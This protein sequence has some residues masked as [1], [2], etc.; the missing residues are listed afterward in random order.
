MQSP[1]PEFERDLDA[2]LRQVPLPAHLVAR[3]RRAALVDDAGLDAALCYVA[4]PAGLEERLRRA[5]IV[6]DEGL[7]AVLGEVPVPEGLTDRLRRLVFATDDGLDEAIRDVPFPRA[8]LGRWQRPSKSWTRLA[9]LTKWATAA[10]L[11]IVIGLS[12]FGAMLALLVATYPLSEVSRS[13]L[14][15]SAPIEVRQAH[16]P[17]EPDFDPVTI[18]P[19]GSPADDGY[20]EGEAVPLPE[21]RLVEG[22]SPRPAAIDELNS[23][24]AADVRNNLFLDANAFDPRW[25]VLTAHTLYDDQLRLEKVPGPI[26]R[27]IDLPLVPGA[28]KLFLIRHGVHPF[29]YPAA[30]PQ[31]QVSRVPLAVDAS[32]YELTR[33]HLE[34]DELPPADAVRAEDFLAAVDYDFPPPKRGVLG[35]TTAAGVSPFGAKGVSLLQI[36]VQ[37]RE[38]ADHKHS[39]T[40]L[41]LAIDV[42][43]SMRWGGRLEM[44]RRALGYVV[45]RL[46]PE[47]LISLVAFSEDAQV[48]LEEGGPEE[49]DQLLCAIDLLSV[50]HATNVGAGLRQAYAVARSAESFGKSATRV[51]LVTDGLA[52]LGRETTDPIERCLAEAAGRKKAGEKIG[53]EV[54]NLCQEADPDGQSEQDGQLASFARSGGGK[55]HR[56]ANA[57]QIRLALLEVINGRSELVATDAR[58]TVTFNPK[59][60]VMYRLLGHEAKAMAGLMPPRTEADFHAGQSAAALYEVVLKEGS[61]GDEIAT[62]ELSWQIPGGS[63]VDRRTNRR[64]VRRGQFA[65]S[66]VQ[67]PLSLQ[68]AALVA[69]T[70]EVLRKSPFARVPRGEH[71]LS[72]VLELASVADT[73]LYERPTFVEFISVVEQADAAKPYRSGGRR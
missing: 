73:R 62:A 16:E 24:F 20:W 14:V 46:G 27:G 38:L 10:S 57:D 69:Q 28:D 11:M 64:K 26:R 17:A 22:Q 25:G 43:A 72:G 58:L 9:R 15:S 31:L 67:S 53:L 37:A 18:A 30:H 35:V 4:V 51:V 33:R 56:A 5:V 48:L 68:Q 12:Y 61:S 6:D 50:R 59:V 3:L 19:D 1:E 66:F 60:V 41:V 36:G 7:D 49:A 71:R 55:V 42:S 54:I 2:R 63:D 34:D 23:L 65:A 44:I 47:D 29:V 70:A 39:P 8:F 13:R 45:G 32:S 21:V 52:V 40:H